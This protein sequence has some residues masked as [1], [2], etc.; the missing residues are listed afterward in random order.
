M[1]INTQVSH[2]ETPFNRSDMEMSASLANETSSPSSPQ[3]ISND[4]QVNIQRKQ[5]P[6]LMDEPGH[7][8]KQGQKRP[9]STINEAQP[10]EPS[11][12]KAS[13]E[14]VSLRE[15]QFAF[16][17]G[18]SRVH[19]TTRALKELDGRNSHH[20]GRLMNLNRRRGWMPYQRS[21]VNITG[22]VIR[23][24]SQGGPDLTDL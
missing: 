24:A 19:L 17:E 4:D 12:K 9:H 21:L 11:Q 22:H 20:T 18:F 16:W 5:G 7:H 15:A 2:V 14:F 3:Q 6:C 1:R 23:F 13:C 8:A 10:D